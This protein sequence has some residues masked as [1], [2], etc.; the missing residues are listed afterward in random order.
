M[1]STFTLPP[2]EGEPEVGV[3]L[4]DGLT[5]E[6]L[7]NWKPFKDWL[8]TIRRSIALQTDPHHPFHDDD[9]RFTLRSIEVKGVDIW[10]SDDKK[11]I[12]F[13]MMKTVVK[14]AKGE[15]L[16][17][18]VFLR[19]GSV[20]VLMILIPEEDETRTER[21]VVMTQQPRV[22]AGSLTFY[23]IPAGMIDDQ[24]TFVGAAANEVFE[25]TGIPIK[26]KDL[27]D[28]TKL[29]LR[30]AQHALKESQGSEEH[31]QKAMYPSPGGCDEFIA[32]FLWEQ[33]WP[34]TEINN[35][36]DKLSGTSNEKIKVKLVKYE[37]LWR[38]GAR[39]AKTLAA[40]ALY[41]NLTREAV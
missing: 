36:R 16:P 20:A 29:A 17:G 1:T 15:Q 37:E 11:R 12:G 31:L 39:D 23:E 40:W 33:T 18:T 6:Q 10:G 24:G 4:I 30:N 9:E 26:S 19:G 35:L 34:K 25:E 28:M 27:V 41:E 3:H 5:Q 38:E 13:L 32:L 7:L 14:N 21:W 22:P 8:P 2:V